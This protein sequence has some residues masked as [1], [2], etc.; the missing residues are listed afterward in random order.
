[1]ASSART[2]AKPSRAHGRSDICQELVA[3]A[4]DMVGPNEERECT[5]DANPSVSGGWK[6]Q[7]RDQ[8]IRNDDERGSG[9]DGV[10]TEGE[11]A[12]C[13]CAHADLPLPCRRM[14]AHTATALTCP[15]TMRHPS[16]SARQT[17][18]YRKG[19]AKA[20]PWKVPLIS[21]RTLTTAICPKR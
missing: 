6:P 20:A 11:Q 16:R 3:S 13:G 17:R 8:Q 21:I 14:R 12:L 1:M 7:R 2:A 9:D 15:A 5:D 10:D 18:V 4:H 19:P